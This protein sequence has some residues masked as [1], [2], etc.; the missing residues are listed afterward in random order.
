[1]RP[2]MNTDKE[3]GT[4]GTAILEDTR[5]VV[6]AAMP[7]RTV[8]ICD[9][10]PVTAEGIRTLLEANPDLKDQQTVDSLARAL[11]VIRRHSPDVLVVDKGFGI[12]AILEW[13]GEVGLTE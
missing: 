11:E 2:Q 4:F 8:A 1:M 9:T 3:N 12:Q 7:I 5:P 13:L 10:Q 6:T